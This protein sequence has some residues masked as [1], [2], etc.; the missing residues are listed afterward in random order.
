MDE[1]GD[2]QR[3]R[4]RHEERR[5]D[6]ERRPAAH[7]PQLPLEIVGSARQRRGFRR[8]HP[9]RDAPR[10]HHHENVAR[11]VRK[12]PLAPEDVHLAEL[13]DGAARRDRRRA[14]DDHL[15][16]DRRLVDQDDEHAARD[17]A[18]PGDAEGLDEP[19]G[20]RGHD[21]DAGD[22]GWNDR[23][24]QEVGDDE[25]EQ[26]ARVA[27][28]DA[29]HDEIREAPREARLA[30]HQPEA[31]RAEQ[32]PR[33][34]IGESGKRRLEAR[35]SQHP[36]Q[37]AAENAGDAVVEHLRHP[38]EDHE[39]ADGERLLGAAIDAQRQ[40]PEQG[41]GGRDERQRAERPRAGRQPR[42]HRNRLRRADL[43]RLQ[44]SNH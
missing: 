19:H 20:D 8:I 31:D 36:E 41:G 22:A 44:W 35:D 24:E 42:R 40:K 10:D 34:R 33:R 5:S 18:A 43:D 25:A 23:R 26:E 39:A 30:A 11:Q 9:E 32:K 1:I 28:A 4:D 6:L 14:G 2:P 17:V 38:R 27:V 16:E 21:D 3:N 12:K 37:K 15:V 29:A 13:L 7:V